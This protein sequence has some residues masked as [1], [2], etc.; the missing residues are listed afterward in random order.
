MF[1]K[2]FL[3]L[4]CCDKTASE[5]HFSTIHCPSHTTA[6][7]VKLMCAYMHRLFELRV[8]Q[9]MTAKNHSLINTI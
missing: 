8:I 7:R 9:N 1:G 4:G 5:N 3:E 6:N 2:K